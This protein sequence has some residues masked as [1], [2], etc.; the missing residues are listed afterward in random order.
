[1]KSLREQVRQARRFRTVAAAL[2]LSCVLAVLATACVQPSTTHAAEGPPRPKV[3]VAAPITASVTE[4]T[5]HTGRAEAVETVDI[6]ARA[7]GY[8]TKTAFREGDLVRKGELLF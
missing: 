6:R 4:F 1:M 5:D 3:T 8:L 2:A 7:S